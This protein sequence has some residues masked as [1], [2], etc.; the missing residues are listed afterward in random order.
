VTPLARK[1]HHR[2]Q[3]YRSGPP[4]SSKYSHADKYHRMCCLSTTGCRQIRA[5]D[6]LVLSGSHGNG[7]SDTSS[8]W[9]DFYPPSRNIT[10]LT[11]VGLH[12][13]LSGTLTYNV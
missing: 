12:S 13:F 2:L 10:M 9:N 7:M 5:T 11:I 1:F 8:S 4:E 3:Y 6:T